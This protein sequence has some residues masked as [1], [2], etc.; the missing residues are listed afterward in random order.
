[1]TRLPLNRPLSKTRLPTAG[2]NFQ[3]AQ[4]AF[5]LVES[6]MSLNPCARLRKLSRFKEKS[7]GRKWGSKTSLKAEAL[8]GPYTPRFKEWILIECILILL[9]PEWVPWTSFT[10]KISFCHLGPQ[11]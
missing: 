5:L 1:M 6:K 11:Q 4:K 8:F 2:S 9:G 7:R 3:E 10:F